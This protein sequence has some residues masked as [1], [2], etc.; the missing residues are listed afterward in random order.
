VTQLDSPSAKSLPV[1]VSTAVSPAA[2]PGKT[3]L[4]DVARSGDIIT[5]IHDKDGPRTKESRLRKPRG[6]ASAF[7]QIFQRSFQG[8]RSIARERAVA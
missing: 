4:Q 8:C 1:A 3:K 6:S 7:L 2:V 5:G